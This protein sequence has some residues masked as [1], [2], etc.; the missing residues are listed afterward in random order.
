MALTRTEK[1]QLMHDV[2]EKWQRASS[3]LFAH[4]IGLS[5]ANISRLRQQLKGA[6]AEMK[7]VKKTLLR[8][9]TKNIGSPCPDEKDL[10]G[11]VACI[12]NYTDPLA[13]ARI[14]FAFGKDHPQVQLIGALFE[15]GLLSRS[16]AVALA[17]I[18]PRQTLLASF[19]G[20]CSSPLRSF[21][22]LC[23]APLR[24]FAV[25]LQERARLLPPS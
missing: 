14:T 10:Q 6:D 21:A 16:A 8:I 3:V 11:P 15:G 24:S 18:P 9:A 23:S 12:F 17:Q 22:A 19:A 1:T 5:V 20:L 7:V 25:A 2:I 13:G 4:F